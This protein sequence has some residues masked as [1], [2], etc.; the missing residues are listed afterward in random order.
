M[1][2]F[3][4]VIIPTYRRPSLLTRC[5]TALARQ[6]L[7][8]EQFEIIV[9]SDGVDAETYEV[10]RSLRAF[11]PEISIGFFETPQRK[12]PASARNLGWKHAKGELIV[13]TD[14]DCIP[15]AKWLLNYR[16]AFESYRRGPVSFSG[17]VIVPVP[18]VP[19]DYEKNISH[20][21]QADFITANCAC[22]REVL[23]LTGGFDEEFPAAW[24]ED[25]AFEFE[26]IERRI[27]IVKLN[28]AAVVHPVR[29]APWGISVK[30]QKKSMFNALL[31]KKHPT[32]Y[33]KKISAGPMWNYYLI[34]CL[35]L[36][37]LLLFSLQLWF[38]GV[39]ALVAWL[40]FLSRFA[41]MRLNNTKGSFL[42]R[43]EMIIT[44]LVI[45]Y[46]SV[47]WTIRG[48]IRYKVFFL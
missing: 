44:S 43:S 8:A 30:E 15:S 35:S 34:I 47:F 29:E 41:L 1:A 2:T 18:P 11:H 33:K 27:P 23:E 28:T 7:G 31:F 14:D 13:F 12:G 42:H 24:R 45:P 48:A 16:N 6:D 22:S 3:V 26:L 32:L 19:T 17:K 39:I 36:A 10:V 5:L 38:L 21:E 46:I 20:L 25:S 40:Y 37:A 4:S 9:V